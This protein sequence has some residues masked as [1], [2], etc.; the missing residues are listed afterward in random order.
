MNLVEGEHSLQA[1]VEGQGWG[2]P[3]EGVVGS[4]HQGASEERLLRAAE[5]KT[6]LRRQK[7]GSH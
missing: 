1:E 3:W 5:E 6:L 7:V 2:L 4:K